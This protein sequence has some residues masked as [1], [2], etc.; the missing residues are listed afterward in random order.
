MGMMHVYTLHFCLECHI[1][2]QMVVAMG[3]GRLGVPRRSLHPR[4]LNADADNG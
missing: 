1:D 4:I 3:V 2:S